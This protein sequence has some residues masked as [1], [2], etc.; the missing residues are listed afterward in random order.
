[1]AEA[2]KARERRRFDDARARYTLAIQVSP[3]SAFLYRDGRPWRASCT[4]TRPRSPTSAAPPRSIR[5]MPTGWPRWA[6]R[7]RPRGSCA[8]PKRRTRRALALDPSDSIRAELSAV[9][10]RQRDTLL[11]GEVR[12]IEGGPS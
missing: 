8:R 5:P 2:G 12:E 7:W 1:V 10:A 6:G 4:T 11:P 3:D 9:V